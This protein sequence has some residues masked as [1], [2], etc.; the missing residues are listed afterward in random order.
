MLSQIYLLTL[1]NY[2]V[3]ETRICVKVFTKQMIKNMKDKYLKKNR[4][5]KIIKVILKRSG[6][7]NGLSDG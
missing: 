2:M 7:T 4:K 6:M 1:L 3:K 5:Q